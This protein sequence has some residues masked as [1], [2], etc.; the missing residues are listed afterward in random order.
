MC[1]GLSMRERDLLHK[2]IICSTNLFALHIAIDL[3]IHLRC[4][5]I[6]EL[7]NSKVVVRALRVVLK[8]L[9]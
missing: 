7:H 2:I 9:L 8:N 3:F 5:S 1:V 6:Y 4:V